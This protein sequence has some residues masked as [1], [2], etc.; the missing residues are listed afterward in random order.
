MIKVGD[1]S[2]FLILMAAH[3]LL[4]SFAFLYSFGLAMGRFE[5][6]S[7]AGAMEIVLDALASLLAFPFVT[8][9]MKFDASYFPGLLGW[10]PFLANS[11]LWAGTAIVV[12]RRFR[13]NLVAQQNRHAG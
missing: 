8:L 5:S 13:S 4:L 11:A 7:P 9:M 10:L 3:F 6:G 1:R 12:R 2:A